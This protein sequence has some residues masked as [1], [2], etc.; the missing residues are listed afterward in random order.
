MTGQG[1]YPSYDW[2]KLLSKVRC[3]LSMALVKA[4]VQVMSAGQW[5]VVKARITGQRQGYCPSHG[6]CP[7]QW[8]VVGVKADVSQW[9]VVQVRAVACQWQ[10]CMSVASQR[11][12][13]LSVAI[14]PSC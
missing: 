7:S 8:Q 1:Y 11:H 9:Q 2:S 10:G 6:C 3:Y 12:G 5:Q 4:T 14:C 13:Y